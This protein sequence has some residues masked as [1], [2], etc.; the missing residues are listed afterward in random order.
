LDG[1]AER[2]WAKLLE[3]SRFHLFFFGIEFVLGFDDFISEMLDLDDVPF[4]LE[5]VNADCTQLCE[6]VIEAPANHI[7]MVAEIY[8]IHELLDLQVMNRLSVESICL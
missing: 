3:C 1:F 4:S 8:L 5:S 6:N 2:L 7:P